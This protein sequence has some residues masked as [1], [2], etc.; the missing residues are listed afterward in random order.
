MGIGMKLSLFIG[1]YNDI[2]EQ[3]TMTYAQC[4]QIMKQCINLGTLCIMM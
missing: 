1:C 4:Y 2:V 3:G